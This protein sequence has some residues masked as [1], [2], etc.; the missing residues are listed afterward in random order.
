MQLFEEVAHIVLW[1]PSI[2]WCALCVQACSYCNTGTELESEA[3]MVVR[4]LKEAVVAAADSIAQ[5]PQATTR[6]GKNIL[7]STLICEFPGGWN[8]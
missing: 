5:T 7:A 6:Y 1:I 8:R 3:C 4:E 2:Y